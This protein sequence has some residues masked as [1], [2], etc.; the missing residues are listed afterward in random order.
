ME[1]KEII[2]ALK[3][4]IDDDSS[5]VECPYFTN[6]E[7]CLYKLIPDTLALINRQNKTIYRLQQ[8]NNLLR[9]RLDGCERDIIPKL[10]CSL[11]R[12]NKYGRDLEENTKRFY[13]E[14]GKEFA[15]RLKEN[16]I[17]WDTDPTDEE[18]EYTIDS[19]VK[20]MVGKE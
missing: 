19:L 11:E 20:E 14:G 18:I 17:G 12:A 15:E 13:I 10:Q 5:C 8:D 6:D 4:H 16:L 2:K 9:V 3:C 7:E 1:D